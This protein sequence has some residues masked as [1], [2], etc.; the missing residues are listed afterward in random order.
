M[1]IKSIIIT[2]AA[3]FAIFAPAAVWADCSDT[4]IRCFKLEQTLND[5]ERF[6]NGVRHNSITYLGTAEVGQCYVTYIWPFGRCEICDGGSLMRER[7]QNACIRKYGK[8]QPDRCSNRMT[9]RNNENAKE[10]FNSIFSAPCSY[11]GF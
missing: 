5:P 3:M 11:H 2:V 6:W 10:H 8:L 9:A 7:E 1:K 4:T